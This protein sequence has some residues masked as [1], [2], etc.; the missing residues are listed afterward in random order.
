MTAGRTEPSRSTLAVIWKKVP[1][2][3]TSLMADADEPGELYQ[4]DLENRDSTVPEAL[5][6]LHLDIEFS[7]EVLHRAAEVG[8]ESAQEAAAKVVGALAAGNQSQPVEQ[9]KR[10]KLAAESYALRAHNRPKAT[11]S[12][13]AGGKRHFQVLLRT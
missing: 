3:N 5:R 8:S 1:A 6:A 4:Q 2:G 9:L 12:A 10:Q 7:E 13:Y 11:S